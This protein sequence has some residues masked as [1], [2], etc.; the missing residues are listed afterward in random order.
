MQA[1]PK[2]NDGSDGAAA[3]TAR[4]AVL[5]GTPGLLL[6]AYAAA[7]STSLTIRADLALTLMDML[8]LVSVLVVAGGSKKIGKRRAALAETLVNALAAFGMCLSMAV[9]ASVAIQRIAV[10]GVEPHG[11]GVVLAMS[12]NGAYAVVNFWIL[13]R[14]KARNRAAASALARAQ[15][16]LFS[17]KL[18]SNLLIAV[19]LATAMIWHGTLIARF[20][21]PVAGLLIA[22]MTARWTIPVVRDTVRSL[23]R[24]FRRAR[25][26]AA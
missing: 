18:S 22:T 7:T 4:L 21:D 5:A 14:W 24:E 3:R 23:R 10:G 2:T 25:K 11:S 6:T 1:L 15:I 13:R 20:I 8:V 26:P 12:L 19:S 9:V 16:C 17:D